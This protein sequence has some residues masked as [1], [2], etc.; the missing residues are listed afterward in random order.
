MG[1][2]KKRRSII[3]F[4]ILIV[5]LLLVSAATWLASG[6]TYTDAETGEQAVVT[7]ASLSDILMA[8]I[9][10]WHDAGDMTQTTTN[11]AECTYAL[12]ELLH[13]RVLRHTAEDHAGL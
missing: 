1:N 11:T 6:Q 5:V 8:P 9:G 4:A 12:F 10:G 13:L 2:K 7:G 3:T